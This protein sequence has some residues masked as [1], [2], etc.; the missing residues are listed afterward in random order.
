MSNNHHHTHSHSVELKSV[1]NAFK[2]GIVL[3]ILFVIVQATIGLKIHSLS[4]LS[5][6]GHNFADVAS[7]ILSLIAFKLLSVK[8]NQKYT[9]GYK[10]T[11]ILVALTNAV[12]L[13]ISIIIISYEAILRLLHPQP[14]P[15]ITISIVAFVG[16]IINSFSAFLFY[17]NQKDD[18]NI[19]SAFLHLLA[20]A[21]VSFAIVIGGILIYNT[22]LYW[23]DAVLSLIIA[24]VIL[25]GTWNLLTDSIRLS[26]DAVPNNID[27]EEIKKTALTIDG[28]KNIHHIHIWAISTT[29]NAMTAHIM[30]SNEISI[31]MEQQIKIT[32]KSVL[33]QKNIH[34][35]TLETERENCTCVEKDC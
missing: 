27:I 30:L 22:N 6:A 29:E 33:H 3:N 23:I 4:L 11:T 12:I 1:N 31:E 25:V 7:L 21:L 28:V 14:L 2:I 10:K 17:K 16:V 5:D 9:Y 26:L 19:K 15:G 34:H 18:L 35:I 32:L 24:I 8:S 20:D 13:L